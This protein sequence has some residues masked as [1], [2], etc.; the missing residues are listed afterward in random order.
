MTLQNF[1][2]VAASCWLNYIFI[3]SRDKIQPN[4]ASKER[5]YYL[6]VKEIRSNMFVQKA[7][8]DVHAELRL[9]VVYLSLDSTEVP[10]K[11]EW[12]WFTD[13]T[14]SHQNAIYILLFGFTY[15]L[16]LGLQ[17][18]SADGKQQEGTCIILGFD[19]LEVQ[20][21]QKTRKTW[22]SQVHGLAVTM[23]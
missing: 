8:S 7:V 3:R 15:G 23:K 18:I 9:S 11:A 21:V 17:S 22:R 13:S 10:C 5:Q 19:N 6:L 16:L 2:V 4:Y 14:T 20:A 1:N 12:T